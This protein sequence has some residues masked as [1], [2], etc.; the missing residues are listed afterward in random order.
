MQRLCVIHRNVP[1]VLNGV[2]ELVGSEN[3]NVE[4]MIN[5]ARGDVAYS[6]LDLGQELPER[7]VQRIGAM[8][9]V[10]RVRVI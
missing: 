9:E 5:K 6:L 3:I 7:V 10:M 2:L 4:H 1:R 8:A